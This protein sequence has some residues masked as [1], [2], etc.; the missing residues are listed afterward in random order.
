MSPFPTSQVYKQELLS[1]VSGG[2]I[3]YDPAELRSQIYA[4][5][6]HRHSIIYSYPIDRWHFSLCNF[7]VRTPQNA[8]SDSEFNI[9]KDE[10]I[11]LIRSDG[12]IQPLRDA[13]RNLSGK[14]LIKRLFFDRSKAISKSIALN[15][16]PENNDLAELV[17][18]L[19]SNQKKIMSSMNIPTN[20]SS[21]KI[22]YR[23]G[24]KEPYFALNILRF[25]HNE[26]RQIEQNKNFTIAIEDSNN[27]LDMNPIIFDLEKNSTIVVSDPYLRQN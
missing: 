7:I 25:I 5:Y 6:H 26:T 12:F 23:N 13:L 4:Q 8:Y 21:L 20:D 1:L 22:Y 2:T 11:P 27:K 9:A 10:I 19:H 18:G 3:I 24:N 17:A 15:V 16:F 14:F